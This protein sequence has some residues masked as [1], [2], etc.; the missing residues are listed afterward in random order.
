VTDFILTPPGSNRSRWKTIKTA[1]ALIHFLQENPDAK[2]YHGAEREH[3]YVIRR[4]EVSVS[5][6]GRSASSLFIRDVLKRS[7]SGGYQLRKP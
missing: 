1:G 6:D 2:L 7:R 3:R 5:V 4:G